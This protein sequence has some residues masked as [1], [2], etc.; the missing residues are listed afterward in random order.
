MT[1]LVELSRQSKII[2][3]FA[4][5]VLPERVDTLSILFTLDIISH[6]FIFTTHLLST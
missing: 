1:N 5:G 3:K 4:Y 6:G 2:D